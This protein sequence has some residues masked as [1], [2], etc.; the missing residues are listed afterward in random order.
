MSPS[1][2]HI[3]IDP[4]QEPT[5][6][7]VESRASGRPPEEASSED[8]EHQAEVILEESEERTFE[9]AEKSVPN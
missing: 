3:D 8:P 5:H 2:D 1:D 7:A 4:D 9:G 6:E